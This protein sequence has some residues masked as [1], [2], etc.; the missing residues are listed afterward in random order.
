MKRIILFFAV[1]LTL[2]ACGASSSK[3]IEIAQNEQGLY[4][5][6][7][8]S[9]W[10]AEPVYVK[11]I[12]VQTVAGNLFVAKKIPGVQKY[13]NIVYDAKGTLLKECNISEFDEYGFSFFTPGGT[14]SGWSLETMNEKFGDW[15]CEKEEGLPE[16]LTET[17]GFTN[18][19]EDTKKFGV[20]QEKSTLEKG[21]ACYALKPNANGEADFYPA[22]VFFTDQGLVVGIGNEGSKIYG[23]EKGFKTTYCFFPKSEVRNLDKIGPINNIAV[24]WENGQWNVIAVRFEK[25]GWSN[26]VRITPIA[27]KV[28][29]EKIVDTNYKRSLPDY[30]RAKT[31]F[32]GAGVIGYYV[33]ESYFWPFSLWSASNQN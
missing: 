32:H 6:K 28:S 4:G 13:Y 9:K 26:Y 8:G 16:L 24:W 21:G 18:F 11:I 22:C 30:W 20:L 29:S 27:G 7:K 31:K 1:A 3:G 25:D 14:T 33:N 12:T 17:I 19:S 23:H 15:T 5:L 10:I 2:S